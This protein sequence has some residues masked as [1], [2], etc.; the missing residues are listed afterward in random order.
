MRNKKEM[1]KDPVCGKKMNTNKAYAKI[2]YNK[3]TY[4]VCCPLC[5]S[6]FEK[7]PASFINN[8]KHR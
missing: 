1:I 7:D 2:K 6:E 5:Q 8:S 3:Q 4:Y